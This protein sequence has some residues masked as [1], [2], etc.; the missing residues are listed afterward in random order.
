MW[1]L[2]GKLSVKAFH[3]YF[4]MNLTNRNEGTLEYSIRGQLLKYFPLHFVL[5]SY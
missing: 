3:L 2:Y 5:S 4:G 1:L